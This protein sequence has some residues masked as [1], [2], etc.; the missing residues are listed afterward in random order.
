MNLE[1][2]TPKGELVDIPIEIIEKL[3]EH[4]V[5][6]GFSENIS[7]FENK[8]NS[9]RDHKGF[10]WCE[11]SEGES[12]WRNVLKYK[13]FDLFFEKYSKKIQ[14]FKN[15]DEAIDYIKGSRGR[16]I[17]ND[18]N[19]T[20]YS[21]CLNGSYYTLNGKLKFSDVCPRLLHYRDDYDYTKID[22]N[23]L[24]KR[25]EPKRWRAE[26]QHCF[27]F[28]NSM[29]IVHDSIDLRTTLDNEWYELGN[30]F[31]TIEEAQKIADNFKSI[32]N[33]RTENN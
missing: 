4:Q 10:T 3:L 19:H 30:Y 12:F 21:V 9:G 28:I 27:Y 13:N 16:V 22:F 6:Q 33:D 1:N 14:D 23:N 20:A 25:Q 2:Y 5:A 7:V 17:I 8:L 31:K 18:Y 32:L 15:G 29:L 24:P 11:A 26:P